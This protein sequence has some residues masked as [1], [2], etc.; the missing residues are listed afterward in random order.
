[1]DRIT[2]LT[3]PQTVD[4]LLYHEGKV[5]DLLPAD[6]SGVTLQDA[7]YHSETREEWIELNQLDTERNL[8]FH[9]QAITEVT[10]GISPNSVI[11]ELG[12]GIGLDAELILQQDLSF[13]AYVWSE[14]SAELAEHA[15]ARH[16]KFKAQPVVYCCIDAHQILLADQEV[17]VIFMV[18]TLHHFSDLPRALAEIDRVLKPHGRLIMAIEPNRLWNRLIVILKPLLRSIFRKK[19]HSAADEEA[20]GFTPEDFE[21]IAQKMGWKLEHV[22]PV[23][24]I[25]GFLHYGLEILYRLLRLKR[26]LRL[27]RFVECAVIHLDRLFLSLPFAKNFAWHFSVTFSK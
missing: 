3:E 22:Q 10:K 9:R 7:Q 6:M 4:N 1:M 17:D 13:R 25:C 21:R 12:G 27:P 11:L 19:D 5:V 8:Y 20:E 15:R 14:I 2:K 23:W 26:R 24:F 16:G 18:A